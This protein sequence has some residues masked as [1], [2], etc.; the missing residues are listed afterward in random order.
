MKSMR[1][2]LLGS[3]VLALLVLVGCKG[4]QSA[5]GKPR[6]KVY[7]S[8]ISLSPSTTELASL[9]G[10]PIVGRTK[11]CDYP[12]NVQ[13]VD[14]VADLKPN[15]ELIATIK[16]DLVIMDRDLYSVADQQKLK[17]LGADVQVFG[18]DTVEGHIKDM[19][20]LANLM[21]GES[22]VNEYVI[23][24]RKN[25]SASEGE[26]PAKRELKAVMVIP[27]TGGHHMIAGT[28]S[29]QGDVVRIIGATLV[30][31]DSNKFESLNPEFLMAQNPDW[32]I[33]AGATS[34]FLADKRFSNLTAVKNLKLFGLNQD[35]CIRR[36]CRV[37]QFIYNGH[38][39]L[40]LG[41]GQK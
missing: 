35:I 37:D 30:G 15:Y 41:E 5:G 36:G 38:K 26:K 13:K 4:P 3:V 32:I 34:D 25:I 7:H 10:V 14:I 28:K 20:T 11:A 27:D 8:I 31:P 18:S 33:V 22:A 23:K 6:L 24:L 39:L 1:K 12:P 9:T 2:Q 40:M 17:D 19:Y 21:A 29:F 16:P